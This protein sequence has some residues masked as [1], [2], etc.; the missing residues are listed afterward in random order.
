MF[1]IAKLERERN[2][3]NPQVVWSLHFKAK[4]PKEYK[5]FG[6]ESWKQRRHMQKKTAKM[7]SFHWQPHCEYEF[8]FRVKR[9]VLV[10]ELPRK[11]KLFFTFSSE[12]LYD[13]VQKIDN[14]FLKYIYYNRGKVLQKFIRKSKRK[15]SSRNFSHFHFNVA[16]DRS[17]LA[18]PPLLLIHLMIAH[19]DHLL[20][21]AEV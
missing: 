20:D 7:H 1:C 17:P 2:D 21:Y 9:K 19:L 8:L 4:W 5:I 11:R 3:S 6:L 14:I 13:F 15:N 12:F 10:F 18:E 16:S